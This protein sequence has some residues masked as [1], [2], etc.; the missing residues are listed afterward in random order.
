MITAFWVF[1]G[2]S[3]GSVFFVAMVNGMVKVYKART[4]KKDWDNLM[5]N[6]YSRNSESEDDT[7]GKT[8]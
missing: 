6:L 7:K 4:P 8:G 3:F 2:V 5:D 1:F